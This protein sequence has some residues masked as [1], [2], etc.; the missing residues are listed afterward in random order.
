LDKPGWRDGV[1][2]VAAHAREGDGIAFFR[3]FGS[4]PWAYYAERR[5]IDPAILPDPVLPAFDWRPEDLTLPR[6]FAEDRLAGPG[7][8]DRIWLMV[9]QA[10]DAAAESV[11]DVLEER[12]RPVRR[13]T[14]ADLEIDLYEIREAP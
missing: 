10:P 2:Y 5:S 13:I 9:T 6:G 4:V 12:Y 8:F 11:R 7:S 1:R 14:F 3:P